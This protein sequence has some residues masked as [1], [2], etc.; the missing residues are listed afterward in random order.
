MYSN[1]RSNANDSSYSLDRKLQSSQKVHP[2]ERPETPRRARKPDYP[3]SNT[4][5]GTGNN[6]KNNHQQTTADPR[7]SKASPNNNTRST[8]TYDPNNSRSVDAR[9]RSEML[10]NA[11]TPVTSLSAPMLNNGYSVGP[12]FPQGQMYPVNSSGIMMPMV[13]NNPPIQMTRQA[14][15]SNIA[16]ASYMGFQ[17]NGW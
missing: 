17:N 4:S 14:S 13:M 16:R 6:T 5:N 12:S 11:P 9:R 10:L 2:Q 1:L 15:N 8:A 7:K 3:Q